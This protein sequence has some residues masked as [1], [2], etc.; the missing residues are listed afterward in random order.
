MNF[1]KSGSGFWV[2]FWGGLVYDS[3]VKY[4]STPVICTIP[5]KG[6]LKKPLFFVQRG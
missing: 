4:T 5:G 3:L 6:R 1:G 2:D